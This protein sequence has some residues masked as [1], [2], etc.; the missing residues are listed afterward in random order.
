MEKLM[1]IMSV[2][3]SQNIHT[4]VLNN[5]ERLSIDLGLRN[6]LYNDFDSSLF[7]NEFRGCHENKIYYFTDIFNLNYL[8][9]KIPGEMSYVC[10]GPYSFKVIDESVYNELE[11]HCHLPSAKK[12]ELLSYFIAIPYIHSSANWYSLVNALASFLYDND[13]LEVVFKSFEFEKQIASFSYKEEIA[14]KLKIQLIEGRYNNENELMHSIS[15]GDIKQSLKLLNIRQQNKLEPRSP[16]P[17]RD[18]KNYLFVQNTLFRKAIEQ[19][20]VLPYYLD[21]ISTKYA[22]IIETVISVDHSNYIG[23][24]MA[25][26]YCQMVLDHAHPNYS[27]LIKSVVSYIEVN[28]SEPLSLKYLS[29]IFNISDAYF[30]TLF[31]KE[32]GITL[33]N[34]IQKLRMKEASRYLKESDFKVIDIASIVGIPDLNYFIKLFKKY[35]KMTPTQYRQL[36]G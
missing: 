35:Y 4:Y 10:A 21:E 20:G 36:K 33:T 30:S 13:D 6:S 1:M 27:P 24:E 26:E 2:L 15:I 14:S 34:Y 18:C 5:D 19:G 29:R 23:V 16:D 17:I 25:K 28:L 9:L 12:K 3:N 11:I 8:V 31:K 32:T 22:K 7:I